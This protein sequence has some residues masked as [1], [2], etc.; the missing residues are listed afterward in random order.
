MATFSL[1]SRAF[2]DLEEIAEFIRRDKPQA[3]D[4]LLERFD[5]KFALLATSPA[6]GDPRLE[7]GDGIRSATVG[8]FV[9]FYREETYGVLI[10]R[11]LAG[12][13]DVKRL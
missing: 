8:R 10:L 4:R 12:E 1:T 13:R 3:A 7:F 11:V 9:I 5:E 2:D 6:V